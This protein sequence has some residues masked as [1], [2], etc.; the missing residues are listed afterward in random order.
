MIPSFPVGFMHHSDSHQVLSIFSLI[1]VELGFIEPMVL[2]YFS[3]GLCNFPPL[4]HG[5][6]TGLLAVSFTPFKFH[7]H[8]FF[9]II[10]SV[11]SLDF[12]H[13]SLT[14]IFFP[15]LLRIP[16]HFSKLSLA[17]TTSGNLLG[18]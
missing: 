8:A 1:S 17:T 5:D 18:I 9:S 6:L 13:H 12:T 10:S 2:H 15:F 3:S 4:S 16:T 14:R 7:S 11:I